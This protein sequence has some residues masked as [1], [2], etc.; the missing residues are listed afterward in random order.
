MQTGERETDTIWSINRPRL[1]YIYHTYWV[2][3]GPAAARNSLIYKGFLFAQTRAKTR[4]KRK[5]G[6]INCV[7]NQALTN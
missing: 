5:K 2:S 3:R 6:K 4:R 7:I 1:P